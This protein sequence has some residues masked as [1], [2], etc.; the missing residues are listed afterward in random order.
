MGAKLSNRQVAI[1][2][3]IQQDDRNNRFARFA[4]LA[5]MEPGRRDKILKAMGLQAAGKRGFLQEFLG[6][7][8]EGTDQAKKAID[9]LAAM[10]ERFQEGFLDPLARLFGRGKQGQK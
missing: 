2:E 3:Y 4:K 7:T 6:S 10:R 5:N 1:L 8:E 9:D